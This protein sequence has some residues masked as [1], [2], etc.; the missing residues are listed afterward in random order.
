MRFRFIRFVAGN[1]ILFIRSVF[2]ALGF[3]AVCWGAI[4]LPAFLREA[5][6][7][8]IANQI[9]A[10]ERF[11]TEAFDRQIPAL[12]SIEKSAFC[13]PIAM[14]SAAIFRIRAMEVASAEPGQQRVD[15]LVNLM[16]D[17]IRRSLSCSPADPFLW[18]VLYWA[19]NT[20]KG[21]QS[22]NLKYLRMSYQL[23]P[24]EGWIGI[25][26]N[27]LALAGHGPLSPDLTKAALDEFVGLVQSEFFQQTSEIFVALDEKTKTLV[28]ERLKHIPQSYLDQF[29]FALHGIGF[30]DQKFMTK[31]SRPWQ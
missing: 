21:F 1:H 26:R 19:T 16:A 25:K 12:E 5:P 17:S 23:G 30:Y 4:E 3:V 15:K 22:D 9:T 31:E 20:Q 7:E 2:A 14:R 24:N 28:L 27:R 29:V 10:G 6:L 13:R 18:L 11:T 8:R